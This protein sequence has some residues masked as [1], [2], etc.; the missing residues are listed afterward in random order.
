M[1][2]NCIKIVNEL[3]KTNEVFNSLSAEQLLYAAIKGTSL[4]DVRYVLEDTNWKDLIEDA[5]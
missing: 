3:D 5:N 4:E 1:T 2:K